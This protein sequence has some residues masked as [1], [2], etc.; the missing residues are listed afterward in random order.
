MEMKNGKKVFC[1]IV[2]LLAV[3]VIGSRSYA[4]ETK[5]ET[6]APDRTVLPIHEPE[7]PVFDV[8]NATPPPRYEAKA[9][10]WTV[11]DMKKG[12]RRVFPW[13]Q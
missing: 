9:K 2:L 3:L 1:F 6:A 5:A 10:G 12:W 13:E 4:A 7:Y 11:V 8:R